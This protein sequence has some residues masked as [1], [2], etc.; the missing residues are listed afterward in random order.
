MESLQA[1]M[2]NVYVHVYS[3]KVR[4]YIHTYVSMCGAYVRVYLS[5]CRYVHAYNVPNPCSLRF[6]MCTYVCI[7]R[8]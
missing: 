8:P 5:A 1:C 2:I 6:I 7:V 3:N 4:T